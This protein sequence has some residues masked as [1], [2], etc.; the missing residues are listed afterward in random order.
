M[1]VDKI[2]EPPDIDARDIFSWVSRSRG[3]RGGTGKVWEH[4]NK[5]SVSSALPWPKA[6]SCVLFVKIKKYFNR[7]WY[8]L[9]YTH[10]CVFDTQK[11]HCVWFKLQ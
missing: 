7:I 2:R 1:T 6:V 5:V 3:V 8:I 4:R 11:P 10:V 9:V